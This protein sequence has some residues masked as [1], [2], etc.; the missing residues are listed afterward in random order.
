MTRFTPQEIL[1]A[2]TGI[3]QNLDIARFRVFSE[4]GDD[5]SDKQILEA[6]HRARLDHPGINRV[7]KQ[8]SRRWLD[9]RQ[10]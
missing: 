8:N 5:V 1:E 10:V 2:M 4:A 6:M 7:Q 3:L 9:G